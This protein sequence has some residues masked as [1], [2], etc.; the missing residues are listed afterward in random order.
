MLR[1]RTKQLPFRIQNEDMH[2]RSLAGHNGKVFRSVVKLSIQI[3]EFL[4]VVVIPERGSF[5][6]ALDR[7]I[8]HSHIVHL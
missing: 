3:A 2:K 4:L 7:S 5:V 6:D 8:L 1:Q